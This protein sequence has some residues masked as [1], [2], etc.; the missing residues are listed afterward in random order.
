MKKL[1]LIA[2][3]LAC[4]NARAQYFQHVYGTSDHQYN[5]RGVNTTA[6]GLGHFVVSASSNTSTTGDLLAVNTDL[7]GNV[8]AFNNLY[9]LVEVSGVS[10]TPYN[11]IPVEFNNG[12]G[13]GVFGMYYDLSAT[14]KNGVYY[15]ELDAAGNVV[16]TTQYDP[17][18]IPGTNMYVVEV[19]DV[20]KAASGDFYITGTVDPGIASGSFWV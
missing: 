12:S 15:L 19:G 6:T 16:N 18:S 7:N 14:V 9:S 20:A 2:L 17:F 4:M 11:T 10:V 5:G 8:A 3:V 13:F 1:L